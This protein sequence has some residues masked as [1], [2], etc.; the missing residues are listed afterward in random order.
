MLIFVGRFALLQIARTLMLTTSSDAGR[1]R[2]F[3]HLFRL[4]VHCFLVLHLILTESDAS[5]I[6][7]RYLICLEYLFI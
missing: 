1:I 7:S 2:Y 3:A 4:Y 5:L 6:Y